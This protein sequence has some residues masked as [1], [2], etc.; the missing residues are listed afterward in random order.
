MIFYSFVESERYD[1]NIYWD[2]FLVQ[3]YTRIRSFTTNLP[4]LV[5]LHGN[6]AVW[7]DEHTRELSPYNNDTSLRLYS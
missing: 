5:F 2:S 6:V 4:E 1:S 3:A 7:Y